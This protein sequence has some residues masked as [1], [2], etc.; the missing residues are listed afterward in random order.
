MR[1]EVRNIILTGAIGLYFIAMFI[2][3][4]ISPDKDISKSERRPLSTRPKLSMESLASGSYMSDFESYVLDQFPARDSFRSINSWAYLKLFCHTDVND[5][6][7]YDGSIVKLEYPYNQESVKKAVKVFDKIYDMYLKDKSANVYISVIPDKNY[8][9]SD[10]LR[11]DYDRMIADLNVEWAEYIDIMDSLTLDDYY[12]TDTH[13]KQERLFD[14]V[15]PVLADRMSLVLEP[16][17]N[18]RRVADDFYGVYYG[19][20]GLKTDADEMYIAE[21]DV[22]DNAVV[23]DWQNNESISIYN[24]DKLKSDDAYETYLSGPLSVVTIDNPMAM[25]DRELV[26]FRDSY[27]SSIAPFFVNTYKRITLVDIRYIPSE[28]VGRFVD[29]DGCDVL[30][31]YSASVLNHS[32]TIK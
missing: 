2:I 15:M 3:C 25:T 8:F 27:G 23:Y 22:L 29:F 6:F 5:L 10:R 7:V 11:L 20:L 26:M 32:E 1:Q 4:L 31:L 21:S 9:V 12:K 19:Q 18:M 28:Y 30:F 16:E 17:Y 24:E 14:T 13:W